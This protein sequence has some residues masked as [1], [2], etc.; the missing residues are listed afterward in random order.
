VYIVAKETFENFEP[1]EKRHPTASMM[2]RKAMIED[3]PAPVHPGA[4]KYY[5]ESG[6]D[7]RLRP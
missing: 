3:L 6:M 4:M 2:T 7:A 1:F 5:K